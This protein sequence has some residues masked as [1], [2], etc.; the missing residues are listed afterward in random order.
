MFSW[1]SSSCTE[2]GYP[3]VYGRVNHIERWI[4][5]TINGPPPQPWL[6]IFILFIIFLVLL[7]ILQ[8]QPPADDGS[9]D[10]ITKGKG[11]TNGK[12]KGKPKK[13]RK[14]TETRKP[15][16]NVTKPKTLAQPAPEELEEKERK[17]ASLLRTKSFDRYDR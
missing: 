10:K 7:K 4:H 11:K 3:A 16:E 1:G 13:L 6:R 9:D 15:E 8:S 12:P 5:T 17:E 2:K 14:Q